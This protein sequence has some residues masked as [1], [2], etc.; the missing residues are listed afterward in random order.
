MKKY[1]IYKFLTVWFISL[2]LLAVSLNSFAQMIH[3]SG[4][5]DADKISR[6]DL[7]LEE[8]HFEHSVLD[9]MRIA[10]Y[11]I[12]GNSTFA[13]G[14]EV[15]Y[16]PGNSG[17][18]IVTEAGERVWYLR[19]RS[20]GAQSVNVILSRFKV[21]EG[22]KVYVYDK[23]MQTVRGP[24]TSGN[25]MESSTLA[26]MPVAGEELIIEYHMEPPYNDERL[27]VGQVAHDFIGIAGRDY[28]SKDIYFGA[29]QPCNVDINCNSGMNWQLEKNSVVRIIAGGTELGTGFL[30][31]N[32][33]EEN[34][35][36]VITANHVIRNAQAAINSIYVFRYESPFCSGPDGPSEY[37][38]SGAE[39][40]AEDENTDFTIV[41]LITFP[42]ITYRPYLAGWDVRATIPDN[43]VTIHHPSG[44][45]KK[46]S[47]DLDAPVISTFQN[48]YN[49]GFWKVLRW[50]EGTTEGG[51]SGSPLFNQDHR[52]V[53][54]LTGGEAVCGNSVNDYFGRMD[55]AYDLNPDFYGRLKPWLDPAR[56]GV[57]VLD[58]RDPY[59]ETRSAIDTICNCAGDVRLLTTYEAPGTGYTTGFNSDSTVMYAEKFIV[60]PGKELTEVIMEIGDSRTV[61]DLDSITVFLM[62]GLTEPESVIARKSFY[63]REAENL[64][65]VSFDFFSPIPL[66]EVFFISWHLWYKENAADE[67]QQFAV[68]HASPVSASENTA[69]FKDNISW[70]PFYDHPSFPDP[71]NMCVKVL[72]ADSTVS[73]SLDT[74]F[75][76][77]EMVKLYPNPVSDIL[78]MKMLDNIFGEVKYSL[79]NS[80]GIKL[81]EDYFYSGG[82]GS[83]YEINLSGIV[84]G[85]YYLVLESYDSYSSHKLVKK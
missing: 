41:R 10:F 11:E 59:A 75:G 12:P 48:L 36:F 42:P 3:S 56:T 67:Q 71:L 57:L 79:I 53:G 20:E 50:D 68:F 62:T 66:P 78:I 44:D 45:V 35:A 21:L 38:L 7:I 40:M 32:T 4:I 81:I 18:I 52:V 58:G 65:E 26:V 73:S 2:V 80:M 17:K 19:L 39:M 61:T 30:V 33:K 5:P 72:T 82:Y 25:N 8:I 55:I 15:S 24:F 83:T 46:I 34:I 85:V 49:N 47:T 13:A 77:T 27:E 29:S 1:L 28:Y 84:P 16:G 60:D 22:E 70:H 76:S 74:I 9:S 63:I 37:S 69:W 54:Y 23:N 31:N 64:T 6:S 51:S 14:K 43:T